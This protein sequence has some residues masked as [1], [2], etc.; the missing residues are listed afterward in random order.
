M[1]YDIH[2]IDDTVLTA[3]EKEA[4]RLAFRFDRRWLIATW[5]VMLCV[6]CAL[7][8]RIFYL[9]V[10]RGNYYAFVASGNSVRETPILAPRGIMYDIRGE[11]LVDNV[12]GSD[13][14]VMPEALPQSPDDDA[15]LVARIASVVGTPDDVVRDM[16]AQA[17]ASMEQTVVVQNMSHEQ[18]VTFKSRAAE[19]PALRIQQMALRTYTDGPI[20]AHVIGYEGLIKKEEREQRPTYLLTD[21]IGKTG[22]EA[23]HE[24][25]LHG[26]HGMQR[27]LVDSRGELVKDLG[28][29]RPVNGKD[30][31]LTIDAGLQ[32]VLHERL[33]RELDRAK[34]RRGAA[35]AI[36]PRDGAV[37]AMVSLPSY[38]NNIFAMG[39]G[40]ETYTDLINNADHPLFNRAV[41]GAYAPGSTIKPLMALAA[42]AEH[43][44]TPERAIE[45]RGGLQVGSFFFGDW[46]A[47]GFT[48]MRRAIAVSSDVYFYTVGGGYGDIA[49][50]GI[51]RMKTYMTRFGFGAKTG[52]DLPGEVSGFYPDAAWK[53]EVIGERWY[54]GNTYHASIGQG[55]ITATPLQV[56]HATTLIANGGTL[57][58]PHL[59]A[60]MEDHATGTRTDIAPVVIGE[61]LAA[62][63]D[64]RV[65]QE[66]MRA[67]I[68]E[69]TATMLKNLPVA[70]AGKTGTA[71][72]GGGDDVHS[73]FTAYAPYDAPELVL[74][75]MVEG[76]TGALSS[77][78]VPV[79]RDVL[80]W[81]FGGRGA[82]TTSAA[83]EKNP[84]EIAPAGTAIER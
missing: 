18:T 78:T 16:I 61:H 74:V 25:D 48:D 30:L 60:W 64:L 40:S 23:S 20:F 58:R 80:A 5:V 52:I 56:A 31:H 17:R 1:S 24:D 55:Y 65:A 10:M 37:R 53:Q 39:V 73:W 50:L 3:S 47:H 67:T 35:V 72:F 22:V 12:P 19:F 79:A 49:G 6:I 33:A 44:I 70:V 4:A 45:S 13:L 66:G 68:T 76:Q 11:K 43:I 82:V 2:E 14:I 38:D 42:L 81:Y 34:T 63:A 71:Q 75:V 27:I 51:E 84:E 77:T 62:P 46:R 59:V 7:L 36:D 21:R 32:R 69:G 83:D 28:N 9:T 8:G 15:V 57:Y 26:T 29:V 54:M 41:G